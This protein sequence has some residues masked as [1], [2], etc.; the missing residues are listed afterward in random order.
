MGEA[1][2]KEAGAGGAVEPDRSYAGPSSPPPPRPHFG[3]ASELDEPCFWH[4]SSASC[5]W[6]TSAYQEE[7]RLRAEREAALAAEGSGDGG[8]GGGGAGGGTAGCGSGGEEAGGALAGL[9]IE[10]AEWPRSC[11]DDL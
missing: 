7:R 6:Q 4:S 5:V 10:R 11:A 8:G 9:K 2:S 1:E 3:S